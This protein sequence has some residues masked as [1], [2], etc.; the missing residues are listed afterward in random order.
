M[1]KIVLAAALATSFAA[2]AIEVSPVVA[3]FS[4]S[5][6]TGVLALTNTDSTPKTYQVSAEAWAVENGEQTRVAT[7]DLIFRPSLVTI[8]PGKRQV[9][10]YLKTNSTG[11]EQA[12]RV[13]VQEIIDP[14]VAK[15]PGLHQ[16]VKIDSP[17]FWRAKDAQPKLAASWQG[18]RLV[19]VNTGTATAQLT[20]LTAGAENKN[21]LVGYV[22]PSQTFRMTL[23]ANTAPASVNVVVNGVAQELAVR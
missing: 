17:W 22:L 13:R 3:V 7:N 8:Q 4:P 20:N 19:V 11:D 10:R 18:G 23:K 1:R 9:I 2:G 14:E 21:G 15:L 6:K 5:Q 16:T 12:Y